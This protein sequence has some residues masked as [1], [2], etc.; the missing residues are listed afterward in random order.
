MDINGVGSFPDDWS[1]DAP[2]P[3]PYLADN[4][5]NGHFAD[6]SIPSEIHTTVEPS[7]SV[8]ANN[9]Y[10]ARDNSAFWNGV[11]TS[12]ESSLYAEMEEN[13]RPWSP[14]SRPSMTWPTEERI[15]DPDIENLIAKRAKQLVEKQMRWTVSYT[16]DGGQKIPPGSIE[17]DLRIPEGLPSQELG[18]PAGV[19]PMFIDQAKEDRLLSTS[20]CQDVYLL[21]SESNP[22][23]R[24]EQSLDPISNQDH[25]TNQL[26]HAAKTMEEITQPRQESAAEQRTGITEFDDLFPPD[27]DA[28]YPRVLE[29]DTSSSPF[30]PDMPALMDDGNLEIDIEF[31]SASLHPQFKTHTG[32]RMIREACV[33]CRRRKSTC[34]QQSPCTACVQSQ[35]P[36]CTYRSRGCEECSRRKTKCDRGKP[37]EQCIQ[38]GICCTYIRDEARPKSRKW[39]PL[40]SIQ[41][42]KTWLAKHSENP[43]PSKGEK[44]DLAIQANLTLKQVT[45]WLANNRKRKLSSVEQWLSSSEEDDNTK[46][47]AI[48]EVAHSPQHTSGFGSGDWSSRSP[49]SAYGGNSSASSAGSAFSQYSFAHPTRSPRRGR[50]R[51]YQANRNS[52]HASSGNSVSPL[53][54]PTDGPLFD[55]LSAFEEFTLNDDFSASNFYASPFEGFTLND[56][57]SASNFYA[58]PFD[59]PH[60]SPE[61]RAQQQDLPE[62]PATFSLNLERPTFQ[63][64][65]CHKVLSEKAWKRHEETQHLP[66]AKWV[67]M[68]RGSSMQLWG[69]DELC[70]FCGYQGPSSHQ[71]HTQCSRISECL[72]KPVEDRTFYRKDNLT[73][74]AELF[75]GVRFEPAYADNWKQ[76][77]NYADQKWHCG[78]CGDDLG[79][80]WDLRAGHISSHFRQ[81]YNM[82]QWIHKEPKQSSAPIPKESLHRDH[83]NQDSETHRWKEMSLRDIMLDVADPSRRTNMSGDGNIDHTRKHPATFL[84]NLCPKRFTRA[85]NLRSHLR[86]HT[87]DRP[88]VCSICGKAF[89]RHHDRKR[90]EG[91]HKGEKRFICRGLLGDGQNW[92]CGRRYARADALGRHLL[93]EAGQVC[94]RSALEEDVGPIT[95]A[96]A[97]CPDGFPRAILAQYP[98][99]AGFQ[100]HLMDRS[101]SGSDQHSDFAGAKDLEP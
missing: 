62:I 92:G 24:P 76:E 53:L 52:F 12:I 90:H 93:S 32:P 39:F 61:L 27:P 77:I 11:N 63:C 97:T 41:V 44:E 14:S 40:A 75:H 80:N 46:D 72:Q 88:F 31:I 79:S 74:H 60:I 33:E 1:F 20:A 51:N 83:S 87:D 73:Q 84:C 54:Y 56:D 7:S 36:S 91:L 50:K 38:R 9:D 5:A 26:P 67:C 55:N 58:S 48:R 82:K 71:H 16:A 68:P 95:N 17:P 18:L 78:F 45:T 10:P 43:Y 42:L 34:D 6:N 13:I 19:T 28:V 65:F 37:C 99:L 4:V 25:A 70:V 23:M 15:L 22:Q 69:R 3:P 30:N 94:I 100:W 59:S 98:A 47:A 57:F 49:A 89:A 85:Y 29:S 64:T 66:K 35:L 2:Y 21:I 8:A 81:G 96:K 86:T 101:G